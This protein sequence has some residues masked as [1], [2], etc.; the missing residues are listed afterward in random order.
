M[1]I[2]GAIRWVVLIRAGLLDENGD[3]NCEDD[4]AHGREVL[5]NLPDYNLGGGGGG[6]G[7][8]AIPI[9][10]PKEMSWVDK[11]DWIH[12]HIGY[13]VDPSALM[14]GLYGTKAR[15]LIKL[16][17]QCTAANFELNESTNDNIL[18]GL[19]TNNGMNKL[20]KEDIE[21]LGK[22]DLINKILSMGDNAIKYDPTTKNFYD[23]YSGLVFALYKTDSQMIIASFI[24]YGNKPA[25]N[26]AF[27]RGWINDYYQNVKKIDIFGTF[28]ETIEASKYMKEAFGNN[29]LLTG[30]S[31]GGAL[32]SAGSIMNKIPAIT[33][34][35]EGLRPEILGIK[36][37]EMNAIAKQYI[38]AFDLSEEFLWGI[39][40]NLALRI[41][42]GTYPACGNKY[43]V[44]P[45]NPE[46]SMF[47]LHDPRQ[48]YLT[49]KNIYENFG[50]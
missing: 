44:E 45:I 2:A 27:F 23:Q 22:S 47:E 1:G 40:E 7:N 48:T 38:L 35:A 8:P 49:W 20:S 5:N 17:F 32:A 50:K 21:G 25:P 26:S 18:N 42:Y 34:N 43:Y 16:I 29:L 3:P 19:M 12:K 24:G 15:D 31:L 36:K 9:V 13:N 33:F 28:A 46:M 10:I 41:A 39:Q 30:Q 4:Y 6:S 14:N 11:V 37:S